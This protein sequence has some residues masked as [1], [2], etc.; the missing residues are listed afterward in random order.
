ML[1]IPAIDLLNG[2]CVRLFKGD[3]NAETRYEYEPLDLLTRYRA[4]G[5]TWLH[6]VD[7]DGA[8][9][10]V[11]SNRR[12]IIELASQP[13]IRIQVGGGMRS[14][15]AIEDLLSHGVSRVVIGSAAI[16]RPVEVAQW[17]SEW[18]PDRIC[19]ALDVKVDA[20]GT[21]RVR[22]RGWTEGTSVS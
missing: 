3:F 16:E 21:P 15:E 19:L 10:G 20:D 22:T 2:R 5:A 8:K 6:V 11:L 17:I 14:R 1:L 9:D 18:G 4:L 12:V 13:N 7:L